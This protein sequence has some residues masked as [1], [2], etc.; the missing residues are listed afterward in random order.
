MERNRNLRDAF[1]AAS[2]KERRSFLWMIEDARIALSSRLEARVTATIGDQP[3][4]ERLTRRELEEIIKPII[5][6]CEDTLRQALNE[7]ELHPEKGSHLILVGGPIRMPAVRKMLKEVFRD[8]ARIVGMLNKSERD[9]EMDLWPMEI[10]ARG[11]AA[12][13]A[14]YPSGDHRVLSGEAEEAISGAPF[15][16]GFFYDDIGIVPLIYKGTG[17]EEDGMIRRES[18]AVFSR[19]HGQIPVIQRDERKGRPHSYLCFGIFNFFL[20]LRES[21]E[22]KLMLELSNEGLTLIGSHYAIGEVVYPHISLE[23]NSPEKKAVDKTTLKE[24]IHNLMIEDVGNQKGSY[25]MMD[26]DIARRYA[27]VVHEKI[28]KYYRIPEIK[29][30]TDRLADALYWFK[31]DYSAGQVARQIE[32]RTAVLLNRIA[33][34]CFT[35]LRYELLPFNN[36]R[37]MIRALHGVYRFGVRGANGA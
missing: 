2:P 32:K 28:A 19:P 1:P 21:Y 30:M 25:K 4:E 15:T 7:G 17:F 5:N 12:Y 37:D 11:A 9:H 6:D 16:Y 36:Y 35:L 20:P 22:M 14:V 23:L 27:E 3:I 33:E 31:K 34:A 13:P 26:S 29:D 18:T 10:V 8:N 24:H